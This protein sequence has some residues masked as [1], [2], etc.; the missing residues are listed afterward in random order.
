[1]KIIL[2]ILVVI[3]ITS[4]TSAEKTI[5]RYNKK[6]FEL[7]K[8]LGKWYEIVRKDNNFEKN[9]INVTAEYSL[10]KNGDIQVKNSGFNE[11]KSENNSVIGKAKVK[12][13][14][15]KNILKVSFFGPFYGDYII[16]EIDKDYK[17]ALV[18]S[19]NEKFLW[20]LS[21]ESQLD[22]V[23]VEKLL[24]KAELDGITIENLIYVKQEKRD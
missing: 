23:I 5:N 22:L 1:M 8:Y 19:S 10:K 14:E 6:D 17:Y 7:E 2:L 9:L 20:I 16:M 24:Q 21:R 13:G 4:C 3:F 15:S 12:Y 11:V 18:R